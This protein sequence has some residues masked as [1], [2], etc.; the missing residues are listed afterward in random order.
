MN[1]PPSGFVQGG[2]P[3]NI[4]W[5]VVAFA[6]VA[7]AVPQAR[8]E[9]TEHVSR[10]IKAEPGGALR[11]RN[12]SGRVTITATDGTDVV[13]D[14]VRRGTRD[15]LSATSLD[16]RTEGSTVVVETNK[17]EH[18]WW[19]RDHVA[20]TDL[21]V[22][23]PRRTSLDVSVFSSPVDVQGVQGRCKVHTFSARVRVDGAS[24][25]IDAH[26]FSGSVEISAGSWEG[27]PAIKV[28]TFS[29]NV[30]LHV[31]DSARGHVEFKS[32]SGHL[33]S[34]RPLILR[35][36]SRRSLSAELGEGGSGASGDLQLKTFS[37]N[38]HIAR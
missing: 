21:D 27:N 38:V 3:K 10:V 17:K 37:G 19:G 18:S 31:P 16:I 36:S 22:K 14:A 15:D 33:N 32:F 30:E 8:A 1:V 9:E 4:V 23:V 28:D 2:M 29:G 26:T 12:F 24:G 5:T 25:P 6:F 11:V 13:I 34:E 7:L 20:E 35:E